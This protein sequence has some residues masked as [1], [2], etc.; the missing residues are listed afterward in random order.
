MASTSVDCII[1]C[2][3][4]AQIKDILLYSKVLTILVYAYEAQPVEIILVNIQLFGE[5][6]H[7]QSFVSDN[8]NITLRKSL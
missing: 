2:K 3:Q 6:K 1:K 4:D 8:Y 7:V 5:K